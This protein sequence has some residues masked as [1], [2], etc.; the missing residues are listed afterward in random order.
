MKTALAFRSLAVGLALLSLAAGCANRG[1]GLS[2]A[3]SPR[4]AFVILAK[5]N[6][7]WERRHFRLGVDHEASKLGAQ[8]EIAECAD[9]AAARL[10]IAGFGKRSVDCVAVVPT[11]LDLSAADLN[12]IAR[13][14]VMFVM[15]GADEAKSARMAFLGSDEARNGQLVAQQALVGIRP[16]AS[17]AILADSSDDQRVRSRVDGCR[18]HLSRRLK[19]GQGIIVA[20]CGSA[21]EATAKL[22]AIRRRYPKVA[23]VCAIGGTVL[24][25]VTAAPGVEALAVVGFGGS[26]THL[27]RLSEGKIRVLVCPN[28]YA[29]GR[30]CVRVM[31]ILAEGRDLDSV[32]FDNVPVVVNRSN[33]ARFL[34][35]RQL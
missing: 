5:P 2:P 3:S 21:T 16:G 26:D 8:V 13:S 17:V 23:A 20:T 15:V 7:S 34:R 33:L 28:P 9:R 25:G 10:A 12:E 18:A 24:D 6:D 27:D 14:G 1:S 19:R 11:G 29:M 30:Q 35:G 31:R 32:V 4:R 22:I